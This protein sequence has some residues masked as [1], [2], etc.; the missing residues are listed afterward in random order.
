MKRQK[1]QLNYTISDKSELAPDIQSLIEYAHEAME[2]A[3]APYSKFKVG[4]AI[5]LENGKI[6]TGNNQENAAYPS[7]LCA[8]R[9]AIFY[10]HARYP[11]QKIK[12][13]A[14]QT[15]AQNPLQAVAPCGG[16]RQVLV[17]YEQKQKE[18]LSIY[19]ETENQ[20]IISIE[21]VQELLPFC[22]HSDLLS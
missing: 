9:V 18:N 4:A 16:C 13:I 6:V 2:R 11:N 5:L 15:N 22:F 21:S 10:A 14:L 20:Q 19:F 17:E 7:G 12:A 1:I 8:E 3:Y